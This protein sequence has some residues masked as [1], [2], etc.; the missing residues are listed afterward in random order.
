[1]D[2]LVARR[3][4]AEK[5]R[6]ERA[7][8]AGGMGSVWSAWN[9]QLDVPVAIKFMAPAMAISADLVARFEREARAAAQIRSSHVVQIFE[10]GVESGLPF[11]VMELLEGEDLGH[12]MR[13]VGRMSLLETACILTDVCKALRRAHAMGIV[14][15][16]LKPANVFLAR[17]DEDDE[18]IVK[19]LDFGVVKSLGEAV[20]SGVTKT[21]E[22]VGTP[23]YMSPEQARCTKTVDHRTD[24]WSLG[25]I[26]YRALT[27]TLPFPDDSG[28]ERLMRI[29]SEPVPPPSTYARDIPP[30]VDAFFARALAMDPED[31][32]QSAREMADALGALA[33]IP[34]S[35]RNG[36]RSA[37]PS[38]SDSGPLSLGAYTAQAYVYTS[39]ADAS[40]E[41]DPFHPLHVAARRWARASGA[42]SARGSDPS[43][44]GGRVSPTPPGS[45][46]SSRPSLPSP[47]PSPPPLPEPSTR[48]SNVDRRGAPMGPARDGRS[49]PA[50]EVSVDVVVA[51]RG[52]LSD[53]AP[54]S[55]PDIST[56]SSAGSVVGSPRAPQRLVSPRL[57]IG[58]LLAAAALGAT[59]VLARHVRNDPHDAQASPAIAPSPSVAAPAALAAPAATP[60]PA[61][62]S[63]AA[64]TSAPAPAP[65]A[66]A[67][68]A[69]AASAKPTAP[70][71]PP[72]FPSKPLAGKKAPPAAPTPSPRTEG[73][74]GRR[75]TY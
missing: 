66:A 60:T 43:L 63:A 51:G 71:K 46:R 24:L 42:P 26:A 47:P 14:H 11:I 45:R 20:E 68:A 72:P 27:A 4:V 33:G 74:I 22:L 44:A 21:G 25:I 23:H 62:A 28:I 19:V 5:Y 34:I 65:T 53:Q 7:L 50:R 12:R 48:V 35:S 75:P 73:G 32:F 13:R 9:T 3:I 1:M 17:G 37:L 54:T 10:H 57:V 18:E 70:S 16:D 59:I 39:A 15:R 67:V 56:L 6:L 49:S 31:R 29:C 2:R 55:A 41:L 30:E 40:G 38:L 69:P 61:P 58:A 8:A 64:S 52:P 36:P